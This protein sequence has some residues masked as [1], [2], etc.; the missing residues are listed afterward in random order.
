MVGTWRCAAVKEHAQLQV[1]FR[2]DGTVTGR[3]KDKRIA[4]RYFQERDNLSIVAPDQVIAASSLQVD[5][6]IASANLVN[7]DQISCRKLK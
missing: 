7:G 1:T 2:V 5:H 6:K 4:G 3:S